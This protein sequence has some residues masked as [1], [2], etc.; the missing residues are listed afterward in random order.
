LH[1]AGVPSDGFRDLAFAVFMPK[2]LNVRDFLNV[3]S[4]YYD[5]KEDAVAKL[6]SNAKRYIDL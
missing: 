5:I 4:K 6:S 3:D 1:K 2:F